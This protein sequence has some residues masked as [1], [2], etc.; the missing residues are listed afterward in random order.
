MAELSTFA[1]PYAEALFQIARDG[2]LAE[3]STLLGAM[4]Q[5]AANADMRAVTFD[6]NISAAQLFDLFSAAMKQPLSG[7]AQN[8]VR[9]LIDNDRLAVLPTIAQLFNELKNAHEGL[10][11]AEIVS[12]Y[13]LSDAQLGEL[14]A[15]L[16]KKFGIKLK[17][18][19]RV[20]QDL[21]GGVRVT[22]G[23]RTLD[24]SVRA[25]LERMRA[26]LAA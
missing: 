5:V 10:A 13:P 6:P 24:S 7:E 18:S 26:V 23:D 11:E 14:V 20:D 3:W 1:R 8:F 9:A 16:Q 15:G 12:A 22:V 2:R 19:V 21:I 25:Q 17:P 4:A